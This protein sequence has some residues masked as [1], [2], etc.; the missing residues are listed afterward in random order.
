LQRRDC[1]GCVGKSPASC[2]STPSTFGSRQTSLRLATV[3]RARWQCCV[4]RSQAHQRVRIHSA[5]VTSPSAA[6]RTHR[7]TWT[8]RPTRAGLRPDRPMT[9]NSLGPF[10]P[11]AVMV[12]R[13]AGAAHDP[14]EPLHHT[15]PRAR[16][17]L[18]PGAFSGFSAIRSEPV[19]LVWSRRSYRCCASAAMSNV[20]THAAA[21]TL[22]TCAG[23]LGKS[24][25]A[26]SDGLEY[27]ACAGSRTR[28]RRAVGVRGNPCF[29][30]WG[31]PHG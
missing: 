19:V 28:T 14:V 21:G 10:P 16:V 31:Q 12:K 23:L 20:T 25:V 1:P 29:C 18:P 11:N 3:N 24:R 13:S 8:L 17:L 27:E 15:A 9:I 30:P 2:S 4:E 6:T 5:G 7:K 22:Q 26:R